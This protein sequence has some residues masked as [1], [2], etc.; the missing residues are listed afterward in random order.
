MA[1]LLNA[2]ESALNEAERKRHLVA[3]ERLTEQCGISRIEV[4]KRYEA[5]LEKIL[6]STRIRD[7]L[8]ILVAR[9][10]RQELR[11]YEAVT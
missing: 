10:V 8:P 7:F 2:E 6:V 3:I 4:G 9:K 5:Q 1:D 11:E